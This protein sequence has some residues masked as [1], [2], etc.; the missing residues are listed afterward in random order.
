MSTRR[1]VNNISSLDV[2]G[3]QVEGVTNV[4]EAVF[5]QFSNYFKV[6][7]VM[8]PRALDLKFRM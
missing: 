5:N 7:H 6:P 8:R 1:R 3:V 4:R 2:G